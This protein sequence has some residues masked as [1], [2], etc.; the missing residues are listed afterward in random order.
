MC[1]VVWFGVCGTV[2]L[3]LH[4]LLL[5]CVLSV[6]YCVLLYVF[7][8]CLCACARGCFYLCFV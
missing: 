6:N 1:D 2:A 4:V 5:M 3:F 7:F 8:V